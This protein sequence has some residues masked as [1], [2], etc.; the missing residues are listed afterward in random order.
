MTRHKIIFSAALLTLVYST[1]SRTHT[2]TDTTATSKGA[3]QAQAQNVPV[4][5]TSDYHAETKALFLSRRQGEL[6]GNMEASKIIRAALSDPT[7]EHPVATA[8]PELAKAAAQGMAHNPNGPD[9][10]ERTVVGLLEGNI[11]ML[12]MIQEQAVKNWGAPSEKGKTE[13]ERLIQYV[14]KQEKR[15]ELMTP[16]CHLEI[17]LKQQ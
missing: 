7:N 4:L 16:Q 11:N 1:A 6:L 9:D 5:I 8:I 2:F 15:I 17:S 14:E 13:R 10:P 3:A 12:R